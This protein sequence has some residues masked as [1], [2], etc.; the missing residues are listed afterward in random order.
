[1]M[2]KVEN[3]CQTFG[4]KKAV[5][6]L[7][8]TV[9]KGQVL[10]LI[11]PNGAGKSTTMRM[12]AG[13][14]RP[15]SGR[16]SLCGIDVW[17]NPIEAKNRLGYLPESAPLFDDLTV[18]EFLLYL[19]TIRGMGKTELM[20]ACDRVAD[21]CFLGEVR[22]QLI[23]TLSKGYRHRTCL[24]QSILHDPPVII[25]DEPTD[26][27][28]P[29]QKEEIRNLI[30]HFRQNKA[31]IL[32]THILEEVSAVCTDILLIDQ[33]KKI[34]EGTPSAFKALTPSYGNLLICCRKP[35]REE[36]RKNLSSL[37]V[38]KSVKWSENVPAQLIIVPAELAAEGVEHLT[39]EIIDCCR[40]YKTGVLEIRRDEGSLEK[41][42]RAQTGHRTRKCIERI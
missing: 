33:G 28:D 21:L 30:N 8:F 10:G 19:G 25:F 31:V 6:N 22:H 7:S 1:M 13:Y 26:G 5:D 20:N 23:D 9:D 12:I 4:N 40:H 39:R 15:A 17:S 41:V 29:N 36:I 35:I 32:S 27:L 2:I 11:G 38:V 42:F 3:L 24:A 34:F 37:N 14:L 16:A 18:N